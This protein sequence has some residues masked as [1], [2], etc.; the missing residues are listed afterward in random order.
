V[1]SIEHAIRLL[2]RDH[3]HRWV[4]ML[5]VA[6]AQDGT[7]FRTELVK[8]SLLRG[9]LCELLG[10]QCQGP[11]TRGVPGAGTL[12]LIGLFSRIDILLKV[13]M[14][15][16]VEKV[17]LPEVAKEALLWRAGIGGQLLK[18]VEAYE[19]ARWEAAEAEVADLG[20][21]PTELSHFYLESL[22]WAADRMARP[23]D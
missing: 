8:S 2:G 11:T 20:I 6:D 19:N 13:R 18:A 12:F 4:S 14:E 21:D 15:D 10:D 7:G 23:G 3:L 1:D 17:D 5:L 9:R 22:A 16:L